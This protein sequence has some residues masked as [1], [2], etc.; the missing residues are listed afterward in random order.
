MR[1]VI[2]GAA[3]RMGHA[4]VRAA[5]ATPGCEVAGAIEVEGHAD[6]GRDAGLLAGARE[7]GVPVSSDLRRALQAADVLIDFT[8]HTTA[9]RHAALAAELGRALVMGTT[10]LTPAE[11]QA[12]LEAARKVPV[13]KAPNMSLG[14]C[15]LSALAEK[16]AAVLGM[17]YDVE[18]VETHHRHKKDAP[19]G[20][21]LLLAQRA[22]AGR[23]Q[24]FAAAA[25]YGRQGLTGERPRGQIGIHALRGG[26]V[27][28][29]HTV[30]FIADG[31][32]VELTHRASS[33]DAFAGGALKAAQWLIGRAPGMYG[34]RD[35]LAL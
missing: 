31:E 11:E 20:T 6:L 24:D 18:V 22:A 25:C 29:D 5:L 28:G 32:R 10:G 23:G 8:F 7:V 27:I 34:M 1:V 14:V 13:V 9:P 17:E 21:A 12:V 30:S 26:D 2:T 4:L 33:R 35:V 15:V 19:S 3:G 16:A